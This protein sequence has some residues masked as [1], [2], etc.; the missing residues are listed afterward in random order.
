MAEV[1]IQKVQTIE[2]RELPVFAEMEDVLERIRARAYELSVARGFGEGHALDDWLAAERELCW[3][4]SECID[5]DDRYVLEIALAG[6]EPDEIEL[7]VTPCELI[8]RAAHESSIEEKLAEQDQ[9]RWSEFASNEVYRRFEFPTEIL[10]DAVAAGF[11]NGML[12]IAA[13]KAT[14]AKPEET[15][16][17]ETGIQAAA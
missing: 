13:L 2:D 9:V 10:V 14:V 7:T 6:F 5:E 16:T 3:P 4:A 8:V 17:G 15:E 1:K 11:R 12:K